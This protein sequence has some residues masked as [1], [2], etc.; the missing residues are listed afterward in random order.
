MLKF[1]FFQ[2]T[3]L[4]CYAKKVN[5]G[6]LSRTAHTPTLLIWF[7]S[8]SRVKRETFWYQLYFMAEARKWAKSEK[9]I[10]FIFFCLSL[11]I[12][13]MST[14]LTQQYWLTN[15]REQGHKLSNGR[16]NSLLKW[17]MNK[18]FLVIKYSKVK[19]LHFLLRK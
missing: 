10:L 7:N 12:L 14:L 5:F 16:A 6:A 19:I 13:P 18:K 15:I 3:C 17:I 11:L 4:S 9:P 8:W 2:G 1:P